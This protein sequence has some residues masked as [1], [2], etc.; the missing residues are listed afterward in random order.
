MPIQCVLFD[1]DGVLVDVRSIHRQAFI[2]GLQR[3]G[4]SDLAS[5]HWTALEGLSTRQ[6]CQHLLA[7]GQ[8]AQDQITPLCETKQAITAQ[9]L[10]EAPAPSPPISALMAYLTQKKMKIGLCS[11]SIERTIVTLMTA[12][13]LIDW[14]DLILSNESVKM[15]KP[16]PEIYHKAMS[17]FEVEPQHVLILEDSPFGI[18]AARSCGAH[19]M[20][21]QSLHQVCVDDVEAFIK[22]CDDQEVS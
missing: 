18:E 14:F 3:V 11:N 6:K 21:I 7:A 10:K 9:L 8:L 17:Y 13:E 2:Q 16:H 15:P 4:Y 1:M 5:I 20:E 19:V 22:T 12:M